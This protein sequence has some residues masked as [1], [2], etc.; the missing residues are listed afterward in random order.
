MPAMK[1]I[2]S[3]GLI[4]ITW[5]SLPAQGL[6]QPSN[7]P[8]AAPG[9]PSG[10]GF[11]AGLLSEEGEGD[12]AAAAAAYRQTIQAFDRQRAEAANA[13]FRLGEVY[14]KMGALQEAKVQYARILREF[15]D[16]VRLTELSHNLLFGDETKSAGLTGGGFGGG[17][18]DGGG[19]FSGDPADPGYYERLMMQRYG[20]VPGRVA[21]SAR[22][23][24]SPT[25]SE[26][27][28]DESKRIACVSNLKQLGLAA[29]IYA[30]DH[31]GAFPREVGLLSNVLHV[32][33]V[34]VCLSDTN[35]EPAASWDEFRAPLHMTYEYAG[36]LAWVDQPQAVLFRCPIHGHVALGDGSVQQ[37]RIERSEVAPQIDEIMKRRYGLGGMVRPADPPAGGASQPNSLK[38]EY[39]VVDG[40]VQLIP[41]LAIVVERDGT[42]TLNGGPME[43]AGVTQVIQQMPDEMRATTVLELEA[44]P[45]T[46]SSR[47]AAVLDAS[48]EAGLSRIK[49]GTEPRAA[50]RQ[51]LERLKAGYISL[52]VQ[53]DSNQRE[54]DG[55]NRQLDQFKPA[56]DQARAGQTLAKERVEALSFPADRLPAVVGQDARYQRLKSEFETAVLDGDKAAQERARARLKE[57]VD[58]IYRPELESEAELAE[59]RLAAIVSETQEPLQ[60]QRALQAQQ[61][62]LQ[63]KLNASMERMNQLRSFLN[64]PQ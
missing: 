48:Q 62:D 8:G 42:L 27:I 56:I 39:K 11:A 30:T 38:H 3:F 7:T 49:L 2:L 57:W 44:D 35:H 61:L 64:Q 23:T 59:R 60:Q 21:A 54:A 4:L 10:G 29:R 19:G 17:G 22:Q 24:E 9:L 45:E 25:V 37:G 15:P 5:I 36:A 43:L 26:E 53:S 14:R 13:I 12:L 6:E 50:I 28:G 33:K 34:L 16:M 52:R 51:E 31:N 40:E 58:V 47:I 63:G 32:T 18:M 46:D 20:F 41:T 55:L 1:T